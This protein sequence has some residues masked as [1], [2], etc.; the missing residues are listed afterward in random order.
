MS[1]REKLSRILTYKNQIKTEAVAK[2]AEIT[3]E[4]PLREYA[5]KISKLTIAGETG[6]TTSNA[7][8]L[9]TSLNFRFNYDCLKVYLADYITS[10]DAEA[11]RMASSNVSLTKVQLNGQYAYPVVGTL[12]GY[13]EGK[14]VNTISTSAFYSCHNLRSARFPALTTVGRCAFE[15][16]LNLRYFDAPQLSSIGHSCFSNCKNLISLNTPN[17]EVIGELAFYS[18]YKLVTFDFSKVSNIW[19]SAFYGC[20]ELS[21][22]VNAPLLTNAGLGIFSSTA[23]TGINLP[24]CA[25]VWGNAFYG[26]RSMSYAFMPVLEAINS[27]SAFAYCSNL[28]SLYLLSSK[29][30]KL[31]DVSTFTGTPIYNNSYTAGRYGDI[32]VRA[33]LVSEYQS[34][35]NWVLLSSRITGLTDEEIAA[36]P[37]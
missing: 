3:D 21:C 24:A 28:V 29:V 6:V 2:G 25:N 31:S 32:F 10:I 11:M 33:S 13:I 35:T 19:A 37:Y 20:T 4:T 23:I 34:A 26:C 14:N 15:N 18:C 16:C 17:V 36:L 5:S 8:S 9:L 27:V 22:S 30:C 7:G 1:V 12:M